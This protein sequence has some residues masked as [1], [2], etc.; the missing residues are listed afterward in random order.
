MKALK[1]IY[2][3]VNICLQLMIAGLFVVFVMIAGFDVF[4]Y[5]GGAKMQDLLTLI[6]MWLIILAELV[7]ILVFRALQKR[8]IINLSFNKISFVMVQ[9]LFLFLMLLEVVIPLIIW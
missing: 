7:F 1:H 9:N 8:K 6:Y 3:S 4:V 2:L 5:G